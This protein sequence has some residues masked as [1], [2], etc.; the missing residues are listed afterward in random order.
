MSMYRKHLREAVEIVGV[1]SIVASLLL[2]A[3]ELRQSNQVAKT[4]I[5]LRLASQL[6]DIHEKRS[7]P[8]VA[9]LYPK[10]IAP[11][12]HLIT[13]TENSQME[14]LAWHYVNIFTAAQIAYDDGVMDREQFGHYIAG[15]ES[16]V[17]AYPGL[18]PHLVTIFTRLPDIHSMEVM[19][20]VATL[21]AEQESEGADSQ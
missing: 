8:E 21:A 9:K 1:I 17:K 2:V 7:S 12:S 4:E 3:W 10:L 18:H 19:Q 6:N 15:V 13:A 5:V 11:Q 14:G 20:P 16:L